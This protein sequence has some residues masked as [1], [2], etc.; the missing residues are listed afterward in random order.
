MTLKNFT[1]LVDRVKSC[2]RK[3]VALVCADDE[4]ALDAI[5]RAGDIVDAVLVGDTKLIAEKLRNLGQN[6]ASFRMVQVP[7]GQ[8]PAVTAAKLIHDG[9]ADFLMKGRIST[10]D[11]LK[12]VL[13]GESRLRKYGLMSHVS[14]QEVPGY[15]KLIFLTDSGMC[16]NPDV[17]QKKQI[18]INVLDFMKRLGYKKPA[19]AALCAI[20]TVN[21]NMSET[22]DAQVL[23]KM[24]AA[25]I[26]GDCEFEGPISY[27]VA[28]M[29]EAARIKGYNSLNSGNFDVF[30]VPNLL[31]GNLLGK[32]LVYTLKG[33][34]AGLIL[35][36]KVPIVLTSRSSTSEEKYNSL[37][38]AASVST[39]D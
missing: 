19:V 13:S 25:G 34:M 39:G 7:E 4:N 16:I 33:K 22:I 17:E 26:I 29:P 5:I 12:G 1:E 32:S 8:H 30:L 36:A 35:G 2:P 24:V 9:E 14:I 18:L 21:P 6:P 27:D 37:A 11:L 31:A 20:E 15:H 23:K 10:G 38:I 3:T 28:M